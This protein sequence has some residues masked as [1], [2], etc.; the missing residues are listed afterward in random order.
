M[1]SS[2]DIDTYYEFP[3]FV[4]FLV[5]NGRAVLFPVYK[6][7]FERSRPE[8]TA[9]HYG[10]DSHAFTEFLRQMVMDFKRSVD[11]LETRNDID[12]DKLAYYGMS[13]GGWLGAVIPAVEERLGASVLIGGGIIPRGRPEANS[14]NYV[15]RVTIPTLMLNGEHDIGVDSE[16]RP[17]FD[18]LGTPEEHKRLILYDTDHIPPKAEYIKET[19]AWLD[20]YLGPVE[21]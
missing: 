2:E 1:Q 6:G 9:I 7:T 5:R 11:Y 18:L 14:L 16:I 10:H 13:W 15:S 17:M 4:S 20:E 19:L 12:I 3:M 21:R 8:L